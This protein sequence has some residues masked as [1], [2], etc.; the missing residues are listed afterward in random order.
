MTNKNDWIYGKYL[1]TELTQSLF[2]SKV[3]NNYLDSLESDAPFPTPDILIELF[4]E[5]EEDS[6]KAQFEG[7]KNSL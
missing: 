1:K 5:I 6:L 4:F 2:N 7:N 3:I